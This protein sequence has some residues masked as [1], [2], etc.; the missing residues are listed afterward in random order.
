M[1]GNFGAALAPPVFQRLRAAY[2]DDPA[3]GWNAAFLLCAGT[4]VLAA[5]AALG[6]DASR[7]IDRTGP[8]RDGRR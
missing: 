2:P 1:W 7:P 5:A 8:A 6:V 3:A 4:Q